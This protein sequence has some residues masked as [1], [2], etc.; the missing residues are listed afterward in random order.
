MTTRLI[1]FSL[2]L[3]AFP[4]TAARVATSNPNTTTLQTKTIERSVH[5]DA[6]SPGSSRYAYVPFDVSPRA[7]RI[8][9]SYQYDHTGG[10]NTIDIGLFDARS[11]GSDTDRRGFR[12]WSGGSRSEFFISPRE[13]TPGY[14]AGEMLS[15]TWHI[16]LGL[17]RV[18]PSGV[19]VGFKISI[20]TDDNGPRSIIS[21]EPKTRSSAIV[22]TSNARRTIRCQSCWRHERDHI[23][24]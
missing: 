21:R 16:I 10:A 24:S 2:F 7:V 20:T 14:L 23:D 22:N 3:C 12:G 18:A 8:T 9:I 4:A 5:L 17:Y 11:S 15:G 19:D 6:P 13:A 1:I